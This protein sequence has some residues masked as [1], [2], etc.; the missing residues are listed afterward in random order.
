MIY[1]LE[2]VYTQK[3]NSKSSKNKASIKLNLLKRKMKD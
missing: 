3:N 2:E 1:T